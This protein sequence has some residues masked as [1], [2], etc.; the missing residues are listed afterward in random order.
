MS[1]VRD[2]LAAGPERRAAASDGEHR[3]VWPIRPGVEPGRPTARSARRDA[4]TDPASATPTQPGTVPRTG[5]PASGNGAVGLAVFRGAVAAPPASPP[6]LTAVC[7]LLTAA[8]ALPLLVPR[9]LPFPDW[10][11][12]LAAA[13]SLLHWNEPG[14][15][16]PEYYELRLVRGQYLPFHALV[17]ALAWLVGSVDLA[18]RLVLLGVFLHLPFAFRRL[19]RALG[20][21][22]RLALLA[23]M[24][25]WSR[26]LAFGFAPFV[27]AIPLLLDSLALF[28]IQL[29]RPVR[30]RRAALLALAGFVLLW[31]HATTFALLA[32]MAVA[33]ALVV[34]PWPR[35]APWRACRQRIAALLWLLP[36]GA[37]AATWFLFG[38]FTA[39][40]GGLLDPGEIARMTPARA[41][42]AIPLWTFDLWRGHG[43]ELAAAGWWLSCLAL[44]SGGCRAAP[45][46]RA[47]LVPLA[48]LVAIYFATPMRVGA[49]AYLNVRLAPLL[50]MSL[51]LCLPPP[52]RWVARTAFPLAVTSTIAFALVNTREA[53]ATNRELGDLEELLQP[54][55]PGA[56]LLALNFAIG[57]R[58]SHFPAWIFAASYHRVWRGGVAAYSFSEMHHWPVAYR[59]GQ[60]PPRKPRPFWAAAPCLYRNAVDGSY[61][62]FVLVRGS[63]QPFRD[64]PPGPVFR[65]VRRSGSMTLWQKVPGQ[66]WPRW[67]EGADQGPCVAREPGR[68]PLSTRSAA[69]PGRDE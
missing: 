28:I 36:G 62:D 50:V 17:A 16:V 8:A 42:W 51:L 10:P 5:A 63:G 23:C 64:R 25:L 34:P 39:G 46:S 40:S 6:W 30:R 18:G 14:H 7:L 19:L 1:T 66:R 2:H 32:A 20:R 56:R 26:P 55:W 13:S 68:A 47:A 37:A 69:T 65:P 61:F 48:V 59:A 29:Q 41:L 53:V 45:R 58:R 21:D 31:L 57:S 49:A 33:L 9:F 22:E 67:P 35:T 54:T 43:D 11:E 60:G 24:P 52:R 27:A 15:R 4:A 3:A 44:A 38:R 12:Q